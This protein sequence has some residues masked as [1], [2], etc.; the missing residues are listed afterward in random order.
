M[1]EKEEIKKVEEEKEL[2]IGEQL[3]FNQLFRV[4]G[5]QGLFVLASLVNKSGMVGVFS[6]LD[7]RIKY[8]VK[9]SDLVCL[10]NLMFS[11]NQSDTIPI[12]QVFVNYENYIKDGKT[13][14]SD[15]EL[16]NALVPN[17]DPEKFKMYH[18][19][20]VVKWFDDVVKKVNTIIEDEEKAQ[21]PQS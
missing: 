14:S 13:P 17:Y 16:M 19:V 15:K 12:S 4:K 9:V 21:A 10:G 20:Q 6:F 5:K 7:S 3:E 18:A 2:L 11:D 1:D 8:T